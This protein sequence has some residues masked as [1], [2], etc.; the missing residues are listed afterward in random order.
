MSELQARAYSLNSPRAQRAHCVA[1]PAAEKVPLE[2]AVHSEAPAGLAKPA[3]QVRHGPDVA[4][5]G[6]YLIAFVHYAVHARTHARAHARGRGGAT[7]DSTND[8]D[9]DDHDDDDNDDDDR[10]DDHDNGGGRR[11][12]WPRR[13]LHLWRRE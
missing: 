10:D 12:R 11:R 3:R 7:D 8:D 6:R 2:Q 9:D 4:G 13:A 5:D 1:A